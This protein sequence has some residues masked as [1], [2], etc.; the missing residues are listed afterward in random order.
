MSH[1]HPALKDVIR[2]Y[3]CHHGGRVGLG[4]IC[5]ESGLHITQLHYLNNYMNGTYNSLCYCYLLGRCKPGP[6]RCSFVHVHGS[7]VMTR[8][9]EDPAEQ[10]RPGAI[11]MPTTTSQ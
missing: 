8:F 1:M 6:G 11:T 4:A 7:Q 3:H 2:P 10:I 5:Q 9:A